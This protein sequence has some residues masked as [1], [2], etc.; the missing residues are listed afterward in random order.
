[1]DNGAE[2]YTPSEVGHTVVVGIEKK[3]FF[4]S[5]RSAYIFIPMVVKLVGQ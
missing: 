3:I 1:V 5:G 4:E 2:P